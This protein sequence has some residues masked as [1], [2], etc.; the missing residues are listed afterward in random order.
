MNGFTAIVITNPEPTFG[1]ETAITML[2]ESGA[3]DFVHLRKPDAC[4]QDFRHMIDR[5]SVV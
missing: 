4:Y 1:E 3:A 2:L 5:K